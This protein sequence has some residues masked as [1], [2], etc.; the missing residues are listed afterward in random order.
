MDGALVWRGVVFRKKMRVPLEGFCMGTGIF[1]GVRKRG[2]GGR[3]LP[4]TNRAANLAA[5][6]RL[7]SAYPIGSLP[8]IATQCV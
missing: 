8:S 7:E 2:R 3:A 1:Q 6:T 4:R 5:N